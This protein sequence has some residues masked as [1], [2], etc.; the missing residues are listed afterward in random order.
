MRGRP[1]ECDWSAGRCAAVLL[2]CCQA[3]RCQLPGGRPSVH[4]PVQRVDA[5]GAQ[6][7][8]LLAGRARRRA[9][10][11]TVP[12][13]AHKNAGC[14][15]H[16]LLRQVGRREAT[17]WYRQQQ[18]MYGGQQGC[19][20]GA[21][22]QTNKAQP[23]RQ[24]PSSCP[25]PHPITNLQALQVCK[26]LLLGCLGLVAQVCRGTQQSSMVKG[27]RRVDGRCSEACNSGKL[28]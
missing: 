2:P 23:G 17:H 1:G 10:C 14:M 8:V 6:H 12:A 21:W 5:I 3:K 15:Q 28:L 22:P 13:C 27:Q 19:M 25:L 20:I 16:W 24:N 18:G 9:C 11:A 7:A 26:Q 4:K